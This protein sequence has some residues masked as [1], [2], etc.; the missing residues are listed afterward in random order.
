MLDKLSLS[1]RECENVAKGI[2]WG[3][4]IGTLIG[5]ITGN[6]ILW[7]AVGGVAGIISSLTYSFFEK[8]KK[9]TT[10]EL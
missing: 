5:L 7:F 10:K 4:G 2:A 3:V 6:V 1:E 8:Y 9:N